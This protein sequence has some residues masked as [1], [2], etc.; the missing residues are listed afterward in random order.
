MSVLVPVTDI[1]RLFADGAAHV[2]VATLGQKLGWA[3]STSSRVLLQM[4]EAGLLERDPEDRQYRLGPLVRR[5]AQAQQRATPAVREL[6]REAL[7]RLSAQSG[8]AAHLSVLDGTESVLLEHFA[9]PNPLQ[10]MSPIGTRLPASITAMG[11]VLLSRLPQEE[12][13]TRYGDD[14]ARKLPAAP[15]RCPQTVG[16]LARLV[17]QAAR[18]RSAIAVEEGLPGV[19][20]VASTLRVAATRTVIG[21]AL[22]FSSRLV[23]SSDMQR[24]RRELVAITHNIGVQVGDAWWSSPVLHDEASALSVPSAKPS[25]KPRSRTRSNA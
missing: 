18:E 10:V 2:R 8:H 16:A 12:F 15:P 20:A 5:L 13:R 6:A 23:S 24:Y 14:D 3:K 7:T 9:G 25:T 22:S 1:L 4:A 19:A 21:L 17:K 11:R